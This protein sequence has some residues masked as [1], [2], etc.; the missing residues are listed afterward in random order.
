MLDPEVV[1]NLLESWHRAGHCRAIAA[2]FGFAN[3]EVHT[4]TTGQLSAENETVV[5]QNS[6]FL[7]A[8]PTKPIVATAAMILVEEKQLRLEKSVHDFLPSFRVGEKKNIQIQHLLTHTSG[9]PDM[10]PNNETL[11]KAH[12]P[13]SEFMEQV[14]KVDL[15]AAPG[16]EVN[17][18]SMGILTLAAIIEQIAGTSLPDFL[19]ERIFQPL[20]MQNSALGLSPDEQAARRNQMTLAQIDERPGATEWGWNSVYWRALG[21]PWGGLLS[22][23]KDLGIFCRHLLEIH[24]GKSGIVSPH[25][26]GAMTT[27]QLSR[28]PEIPAS[29]VQAKPW[30][31]GW[32]LNW[33]THPRGFGSGLASHVYGHW[34]ATGTLV[35]MDP[36]QATYGVLL[37]TEPL[38]DEERRPIEYADQVAQFFK[39][40][41]LE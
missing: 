29:M 2:E 37:T 34:G 3:G 4:Y 1:W 31:L 27:N 6:L 7:I 40:R 24:G 36:R 10:L 12:A 14:G 23:V 38:G 33:P 11:R 25:T 21:A 22:T 19:D 35:W 17:Y 28:L 20:D 18:Q 15:I 9:L 30:G 32:Q 8:S 16:T 39:A 26:L 13:L 5:D 41:H